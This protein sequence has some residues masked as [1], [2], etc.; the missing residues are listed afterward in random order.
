MSMRCN[1]ELVT[2]LRSV[3]LRTVALGHVKR[4]LVEFVQVE[5]KFG[6][7]SL[8]RAHVGVFTHG[9]VVFK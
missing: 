9:V 3:G 4:N 7:C 2:V 1:L 8:A 5:T 6:L